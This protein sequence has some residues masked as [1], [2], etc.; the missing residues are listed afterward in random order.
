[1]AQ[2]YLRPL[3]KRLANASAKVAILEGARAVGKTSL[4]RNELGRLGYNYLSLADAATYKRAKENIDAWVSGIQRPAI[5]DEAQRL[6]D[7]P[8][9]IKGIVDRSS[10][11]QPQFILTGSAS[12]NRN[13]LD[14]QD[15]LTRRSQRFTLFPLTQAE[16]VGSKT[17][18][19]EALLELVPNESF[20][21]SFSVSGLMPMMRIGGFPSYVTKTTSLSEKERS[22]LIKSDINSVL[23]DTLLPEERI[24]REIA[25]RL[26]S[27]LLI[28]PGAILN[29]SALAN[30]CDVS[31]ITATRY[32][33]I[34]QRRYLI[35]TLR[36][37]AVPP[38]KQDFTRSKVHPIDTSFS[39]EMLREAGVSASSSPTTMGRLFESFVINQIAPAAAW[40]SSPIDCFYWREAGKK[41]KE[42]DLVLL[43]SG[44]LVG[45]EVKMSTSVSAHDFDSLKALARD[46]RFHRGFIIYCGERI[47]KH[48]DGLWALPV[49]ALWEPNA[50]TR[51][52]ASA[53]SIMKTAKQGIPPQQAFDERGS[54]DMS[55]TDASIFLS[56]RHDDN[57]HLDGRIVQ[58]AKDLIEE[59]NYQYGTTIDLFI[60][61]ETLG[62]G[63]IW[64]QELQRRIQ[65]T[66]F[67][68]PAVTPRYIASK[69]CRDEIL[70]FNNK[71]KD[72]PNSSILPVLWQSIDHLD[73]EFNNDPV[74]LLLKER[75]YINVE[76]L[77]YA[78]RNSIE[79]RRSLESTARRLRSAV[80]DNVKR[81]QKEAP[82]P[83]VPA[84]DNDTEE[85]S[86][87]ERMQAIEAESERVQEYGVTIGVSLEGIT[88][89]I[90]ENPIPV[91][92]TAKTMLAWSALIAKKTQPFVDETEK[93]TN[94]LG[95]FWNSYYSLLSEYLHIV[96]NSFTEKNAI[97]AL[98]GIE[99]NA[100]SLMRS[101]AVTD[102]MRQADETLQMASA[103]APRLKPLSR[104]IRNIVQLFSTISTMCSSLL[105]DIAGIRTRE[106]AAEIEK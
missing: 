103:L 12:I 46:K 67:I 3:A 26:L 1:M 5:I 9:A 29:V 24:D 85:P 56:Y 48:A 54:I 64:P 58:Y 45:I 25:R 53:F 106:K 95:S 52:Q 91:N 65:A 32:I 23:G 6:A 84:M 43:D 42:V 92:T 61:S 86:P 62:W 44:K 55:S 17:N 102:D 7:L 10:S 35:H 18:I 69:S 90:N 99:E 20:V 93:A 38:R 87:L 8:L 30:E 11:H 77:R 49:S 76:E 19:A 100:L 72:M 57:E 83:N 70:S 59:Y 37:L 80:T 94:E 50:F 16:I 21:A 51:E 27:K 47:I 36:N 81:A 71:L 22:S 88:A 97:D 40:S 68:M 2:Y 75:H 14:G 39:I 105:D 15:P 63:E 41:P 101:C 34:F 74:A 98:N 33:S 28:T 96:D 82:L 60:D 73:K 104:S 89:V 31:A 13:G 78:E 4:V 66:N 79:Y